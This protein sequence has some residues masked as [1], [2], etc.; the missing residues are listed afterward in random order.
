M[1]ATEQQT[2]A[3]KLIGDWCKW[4]VAVETFSIAA[5]GAAFKSDSGWTLTFP[6]AALCIITVVTFFLSIILAAM[7]LSCLPEAVQDISPDQS[8]WD[9]KANIFGFE[10]PLWQVIHWQTV[11]FILGLGAFVVAVIWTA[12][13]KC[14]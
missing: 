2:D 14:R 8:V 9:R 5:I 1:A 10:R 7:A 6:V 12:I 11:L 13:S 3:I 4:F